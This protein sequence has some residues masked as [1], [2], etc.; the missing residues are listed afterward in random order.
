MSI[1]I[2]FFGPIPPPFHGQSLAFQKA[3]EIPVDKKTIID[4]NLTGKSKLKKLALS[5][6]IFIKLF[7]VFMFKSK[8]DIVYFTCS[9]S[10]S[11]SFR[12]V[13]LLQLAGF[14]NVPV[15]NH[16]HGSDFK[17]FYNR[18]PKLYQA[19]LKRSYS[20]VKH[21]IVL[22]DAMRDQFDMFPDM[23]VSVVSN[24]FNKGIGLQ[25]QNKAKSGAVNFVFLS[26]IMKTKGVFVLLE[27]FKALKKTYPNITLKI[28]GSPIGDYELSAS[29]TAVLF[30]DALKSC[31]GVDYIGLVQGDAKRD[32]LNQSSVFVLPSY[33]KSEAIPLSIIEAMAS[34]CA[35]ITTDHNYLPS[36]VGQDNGLLV[37]PNDVENLVEAMERYITSADLLETHQLNNVAYASANFSEKAYLLGIEQV[38]EQTLK[39]CH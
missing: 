7:Y 25:G 8:P 26:N 14:R 31:T 6:S 29:D 30:S 23:K 9:R 21:S 39:D 22:T 24:F 18:V 16:L 3:T 2:L 1:K 15:V 37:K 33:Y 5:F 20:K 32:L 35:I 34:G 4:I 36:L 19:I 10:L 17:A 27:A 12:D 13:V 38:L 11:G 28:A